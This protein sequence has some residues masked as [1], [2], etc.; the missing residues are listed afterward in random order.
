MRKVKFYKTGDGKN[1]GKNPIR[2]S[3]VDWMIL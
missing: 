1:E 3:G 2:R